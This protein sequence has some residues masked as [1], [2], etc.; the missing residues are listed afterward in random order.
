MKQLYKLTNKRNAAKQIGTRVR[1]LERAQAA[2]HRRNLQEKRHGLQ[3]N[4]PRETSEDKHQSDAADDSD[5]R[6]FISPSQ[7]DWFDIY[8]VLKSRSSDPAY[9]VSVSCHTICYIILTWVIIP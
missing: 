9:K 7:N 8:A 3:S 5:L 1:H 4:N 6:Y 2:S